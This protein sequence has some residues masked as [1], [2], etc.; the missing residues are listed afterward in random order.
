MRWHA[1]DRWLDAKDGAGKK[2]SQLVLEPSRMQYLL[3]H[4]YASLGGDGSASSPVVLKGG[5]AFALYMA[6][7][8]TFY[9]ESLP[10]CLH[11][12]ANA[13]DLDFACRSRTDVLMHKT[14]LA[15]PWLSS[16]CADAWPSFEAACRPWGLRRDGGLGEA[17]FDGRRYPLEC[18]QTAD[19]PIK[20]SFHGELTERHSGAEF[21]L[22][23][24]GAAIW[25]KRLRRAAIAAFVDILLDSARLPTVCVMGMRI[26]SPR[27]MLKALRRMTFHEADYAPWLAAMGDEAKQQRRVERLVKL[28]FMVDWKTMGGA[29]R[30][31]SASH[32]LQNRWTKAL[33]LLFTCD[34]IGLRRLSQSAPPQLRCLLL[35]SA[36]TVELASATRTLDDYLYW[37]DSAVAPIVGDICEDLD[38]TD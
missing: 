22:V 15:L 8:L 31:A 4:L 11:S 28:S 2:V 13:A 19:L 27:S 34:A 9:G 14:A 12:F 29:C 25:H 16:A 37:I 35:C 23:R 21:Q 24:I 10:P 7:E 5:A 18:D 3:P 17:Y 26:Q 32:G 33:T 1:R 20:L 36:R 38:F 30:G 6:R